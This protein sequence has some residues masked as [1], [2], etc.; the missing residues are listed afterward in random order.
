LN[1]AEKAIYSLEEMPL[2]Y[3]LV[4]DEFLA[5]Q[6]FRFFPV[7]KYLVFYVVRE[8]TNIVVIER[9]LYGKRDWAAILSGTAHH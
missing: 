4:A 8:E 7:H 3:P 6:G 2:R 1:D 9:F 5:S